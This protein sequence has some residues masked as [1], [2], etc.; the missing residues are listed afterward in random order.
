[1]D[2]SEFQHVLLVPCLRSYR[3]WESLILK[4]EIKVWEHRSSSLLLGHVRVWWPWSLLSL[5]QRDIVTP[6]L[7]GFIRTR[8]GATAPSPCK[9]HHLPLW[10]PLC[11]TEP[12]SP[13]LVCFACL[14]LPF[15]L[16]LCY[17]KMGPWKG[18]LPGASF[19]HKCNISRWF[20]SPGTHAPTLRCAWGFFPSRPSVQRRPNVCCPPVLLSNLS[21]AASITRT[22]PGRSY[23]G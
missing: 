23:P 1:M 17:K 14:G 5:D 13:A 6:L 16:V 10:S 9:N 4:S 8:V 11:W 20:S 3:V 15:M 12:L 18:T 19:I 22:P 21:N 2:S 7:G